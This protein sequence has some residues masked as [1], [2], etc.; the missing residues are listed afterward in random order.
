[1]LGYT[2]LGYIAL[3]LGLTIWVGQTLHKNGR[4]FLLENYADKTILADAI[5]NMLLVGFYLINIG[6]IAFTMRIAGAPPLSW[7][8]AGEFLSVK[9]GFIAILL[10]IMHFTLMFVLQRFA[11]TA[12]RAKDKKV[13]IADKLF[14]K[15]K[16]KPIG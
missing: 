10:G 4:I 15:T 5:N 6:F 1:M 2:Y 16:P 8:Q 13:Q 12:Q 3:S 14:P 11:T 7:T 9:I